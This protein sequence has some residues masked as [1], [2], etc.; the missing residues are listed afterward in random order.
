MADRRGFLATLTAA[1]MA[2]TLP[3]IGGRSIGS[4]RAA[5]GAT[6]E[7][8]GVGEGEQFADLNRQMR[9]YRRQVA[10]AQSVPAPD[11]GGDP[12]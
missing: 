10:R 4:D 2:I 8:P 7:R 9:R 6:P 5:R 12:R 3:G 1:A 11:H